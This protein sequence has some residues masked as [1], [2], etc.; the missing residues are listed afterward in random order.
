MRRTL[1]LVLG[2]L[3]CGGLRAL[4][5]QGAD[6][7]PAARTIRTAHFRVHFEPAHEALARRAAAYAEQAWDA[8]AKELAVPDVPVEVL[9]ADNVDA[10]NGFATVF[11]TNRVVL[12]ALPP[13][14]VPELRHYDDWLQIVMT[15]EL[16]HIF[17]LDRARGLWKLGR[18]VFGRH[19]GLAP[20]A[21]LPSWIK[22]GI[23]VHY[24]V[25]LTGAGRLAS[26]EWP[27]LARTAAVAGRVP[28]M[29]E[30]SLVTSRFPLAQH[31]YG[32]GA[33]LITQMAARGDGQGLRR[34]VDQVGGHPIPFRLNHAAERAF[35]V[36]FSS[37]ERVFRDSLMRVADSARAFA[38]ALQDAPPVQRAVGMQWFAEQPRW[39]SDSTVL[40]TMN[41]GE[42]VAGVYEARV[43]AATSSAPITLHRLSRR[44]SL[45]ATSQLADG[46][47]IF[48]QSEFTDPFSVRTRLWRETPDGDE[49]PLPG[50]Q[51]LFLPD[52][53]AD[54]DIVAIRAI[55]G[56]TEIVRV[57]AA[58]DV[59][60]LVPGTLD[61]AWTEP[62]W[63]ARGERIVAV[64]FVRGGVQEIV[65]FD[66]NGVEQGVV[67]RARGLLVSPTFTPDGTRLVWA[68]DRS[69][70]LQ[71]VMADARPGAGDAVRWLTQSP[72]GV[73]WPS[74]SPDGSRV[75]ALE[76]DLRGW[77]LIVLPMHAG[78][79]SVP[80]T[81]GTTP[82]AA[83]SRA[84]QVMPDS[85][86]ST[87]YRP[88]RQLLPHWW[89]PIVGEG[90]DGGATY[91]ASSN[92]R[93][94][95][96]QHVWAAQLTRHP[97]RAE[98]EG[99][100]IWRV[101]ALPALGALQPTLDVSTSQGWDRF[102]LV[103]SARRPVGELGRRARFGTVAL[104]LAR[105][106]VRTSTTLSLGAQVERRA[107][108]T[109]PDSL[110]GALDPL[111]ARGVTYPSVFASG[112]WSNTM[113]PWRGIS[114]EDGITLGATVQRRWRED[115]RDLGS[116]RSTGELRAYQ[117]FRVGGFAHHVIAAR[118]TGGLTDRNGT[119]E[120]NTGGTSGAQ[121]ELVPGVIVGD[122]ARLFGVRGFAPATQ[123]GSRAVAG[124]V[125][126]RAPLVMPARGVGLVPLFVD[127]LSVAVFG[128]AGRAWCGGAERAGPQGAVLCL[129]RGVRDGWL[130]SAGAEVALDLGVQWDAP[131]RAR[132]GVAQP[133][134]RP[135]DV[136]RGTAWYFT[137]GTA[138]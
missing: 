39:N 36:S 32:Y 13:Q 5:A 118:V 12:Y 4:H 108:V 130:A 10:T 17:H 8:L 43:P 103:D 127:R 68:D 6:P 58:G 124:T 87:P 65:L 60:T 79:A 46:T 131:Y 63:D 101:R 77:Q 24:E 9:I 105:P 18:F 1:V 97:S 30:W 26:S 100:A 66:A 19:P 83:T 34:F 54:G 86:P 98:M 121:A 16:V 89:M 95:R 110:L 11:P 134:A 55:P 111:F 91:G 44:N 41:D 45:E 85:S 125:E 138:F 27:M 93:D 48:A 117:G 31:A 73:S 56:T 67:H 112:V 42:D 81:P 84:P 78:W 49:A 52:A 47:R 61:T 80:R 22:E 53:R 38:A 3:M 23:A 25:A 94:V 35:G 15:H 96:G 119:T 114:T 128:D 88:W 59:R 129:P 64:R 40:L 113:R 72:T 20:N 102:S 75:V 115:R 82:Y 116:W 76:S 104:S 70:A 90:S 69:G 14:F 7:R 2:L 135:A 33:M 37:A 71:L 99:S 133:V 29:S 62:R 92:G 57:A 132:V 107:F 137:L 74:V 120:F 50:T 109:R 51:R 123:R 106:R 28:R 21:F 136:S 122:P 126:Y